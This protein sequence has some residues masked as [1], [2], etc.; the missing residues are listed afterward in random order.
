[1]QSW[2]AILSLMAA[3]SAGCRD[4][5]INMRSSGEKDH[6]VLGESREK[7]DRLIL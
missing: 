1:M 7:E 6:R 3:T 2:Q 5:V 4:R